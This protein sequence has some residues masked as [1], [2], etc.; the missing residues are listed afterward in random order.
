MKKQMLTLEMTRG[1]LAASLM[2]GVAAC[3][4]QNDGVAM[5]TP[6][7]SDSGG[8]AASLGQVPAPL[9][10]LWKLDSLQEA[11]QPAVSVTSPE[12]FTARFGSQGQVDLVADCNRCTAAFTATEATLKVNLMACT[13]AYCTTA[14]LDTKFAGLVGASTGWSVSGER[15]SLVSSSGTLRLKR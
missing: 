1:V 6:L 9:A 3:G 11:G 5:P 13:V 8:S 12:R 2:L 10:G 4:T 7:G 15:L 14:P